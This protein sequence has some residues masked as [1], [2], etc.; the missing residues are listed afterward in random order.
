LAG[1]MQDTVVLPTSRLTRQT[2]LPW[3]EQ[4]SAWPAAAAAPPAAATAPAAPQ[5]AAGHHSCTAQTLTSGTTTRA[6]SSFSSFSSVELVPGA[7]APVQCMLPC[8]QKHATRSSARFFMRALFQAHQLML[9]A[10][11][12][13]PAAIWSRDFCRSRARAARASSPISPRPPPRS[14]CWK[15]VASARNTAAVR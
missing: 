4:R 8:T 1:C 12:A 6:A 9:W 5:S 13:S 14:S 11:T 2:W 15:A 3:G 10:L 7:V